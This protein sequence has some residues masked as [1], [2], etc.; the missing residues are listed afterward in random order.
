MKNILLFSKWIYQASLVLCCLAWGLSGCSSPEP[1]KALVKIAEVKLS[2]PNAQTLRVQFEYDVE[3]DVSLP[4]PY[5]EVLVF[6]LE[7]EVK[8]A[9]T[10]KP[11]T[12]YTDWVDVSLSV[13]AETGIDWDA[14]SD[15]QTCCTV[16]LKGAL[17]T[18]GYE[19]ISNTV[20]VSLEPLADQGSPAAPDEASS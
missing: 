2:R 12:L 17:A 13:P 1:S 9:G 18:G 16:S 6:P 4:L 5:S 20:T 3:Q 7:P 15:P 8:L 10:L 19:R 14:L 11:L